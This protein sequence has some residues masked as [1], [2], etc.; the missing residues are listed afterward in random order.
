V[1]NSERTRKGEPFYTRSIQPFEYQE[2]S[3]SNALE[4]KGK[5]EMEFKD[6]KKEIESTRRIKD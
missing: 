5:L 4:I 2:T 6:E 1:K 3:Q